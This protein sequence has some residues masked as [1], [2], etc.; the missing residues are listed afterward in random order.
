MKLRIGILPYSELPHLA[1]CLRICRE[2]LKSDHEIHIF[3]SEVFAIFPGEK[4]AWGE[5]LPKF[6]LNGLQVIHRTQSTSFVD[7]LVM[8]AKE[9]RLDVIILDAVWQGL[10]FE[11]RSLVRHVVVH[12]AGLPDFRSPD[13]PPWSFAQP[14]HSAEIVT[15]TRRALESADLV[16]AV[17]G[18][19]STV[20]ALSPAGKSI[21]DKYE[22]GCTELGNLP[23]IRAMSL[24][25]CVEFPAERG[26]IEYFGTL[27]PSPRDIDWTPIP[28]ELLEDSRPLIACV[29]GTTGLQTRAE[30]QWLYAL[31]K[32]LA[33]SLPRCQVITVIPQWARSPQ[34]GSDL[35]N[36]AALY[37][38]VPL[39]ELLSM[40]RTTKLLVSTPGVGAFREAIASGTP[41]VAVPRRL[42]QFGVAAR[43][44]FF[45]VGA[46]LVSHTL[47]STDAV[48]RHVAKTFEDPQIQ[49]R[50]DRL[51]REFAAFDSTM[52]LRHFIET[53]I[54]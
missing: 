3:R 14:N 41:I 21:A 25:P 2:L 8:Q 54:S 24:S 13:L 44:Q 39:W 12:H 46:M 18:A 47:P 28:L 16:R 51:R 32:T 48:V 23:A 19:L 26:R 31:T 30:Y 22:F 40:R 17:R 35:P 20:K 6:G 50:T 9:R 52:P 7:W 11:L 53:R 36:N 29:F 45:G 42:D 1:P 10:A 38:W 5:L 34:M 49:A 43:V 15:R 37:S 33:D 4:Q 27:L